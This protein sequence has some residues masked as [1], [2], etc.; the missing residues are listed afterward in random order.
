VNSDNRI[1]ASTP[2]LPPSSEFQR[3]RLA[4][5]PAVG[6]LIILPW[7][8]R[9]LLQPPPWSTTQWLLLAAFGGVF[10]LL[11]RF[12]YYHLKNPLF[13][14]AGG[15]LTLFGRQPSDEFTVPLHVVRSV[16]LLPPTFAGPVR[17]EIR[18]DSGAYERPLFGIY[19]KDLDAVE[20]YFRGLNLNVSWGD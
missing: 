9:F 8:V 10:V 19:K 11:L 12:G 4:G 1:D 18:T 3:P 14:Y 5:N 17:V 7:L 15:K 13:R 6:A 16:R 2:P 20:R